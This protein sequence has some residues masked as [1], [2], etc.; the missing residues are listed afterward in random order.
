MKVNFAMPHNITTYIQWFVQCQDGQ[1]IW[2]FRKTTYPQVYETSI[3]PVNINEEV[4]YMAIIE[5]TTFN[6][7]IS[8]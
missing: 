3:N 7:T 6:L 5:I 1:A 2:L 4:I 8:R